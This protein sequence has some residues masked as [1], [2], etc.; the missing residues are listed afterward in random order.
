MCQNHIIQCK[1]GQGK[2]NFMNLQDLL[3]PEILENLYCPSCSEGVAFNPKT[4]VR[5]SGWVLD[6]DMAA[7]RG[8]LM[9]NGIP[10]NA[11]TP[12]YIFDKGFFSWNGFTPTDIKDRAEERSEIMKLAKVDRKKFIYALKEWGINRVNR[13]KEEGWRKTANL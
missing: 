5:D 4:M 12:D 7:A 1:C 13:L 8:F 10:S 3:P 9:S 11:I 2:A 6:F